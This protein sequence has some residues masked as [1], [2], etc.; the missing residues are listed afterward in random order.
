MDRWD[1]FAECNADKAPIELFTASCC[2]RCMNPECTRSQAGK[3]KFDQRVATWYERLYG[4]V[5]RM[6]T[7]DPRY[8]KISGQRF[9]MLD[10]GPTPSISSA[11]LDPRDLEK[12]PEVPKLRLPVLPSTKKS[13]PPLAAPI[14]VEAA[15]LPTPE[16]N[17]KY[18]PRNLVLANAPVQPG[19]MI[20]SA[21]GTPA[22]PVQAPKDPWAVPLPA[23]P[24]GAVVVKPGAT[25]KLRGSGV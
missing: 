6:P 4:N 5:P 12:P 20:Q 2:A 15:S 22:A 8:A 1:Q 19:Q 9:L 23:A 25:V 17:Q 16:T 14:P 11:W 7:E 21:T 18:S 24:A 13:D 10:G 3:F